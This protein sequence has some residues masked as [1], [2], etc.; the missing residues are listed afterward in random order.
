MYNN[1]VK[2]GKHELRKPEMRASSMPFCP[3]QYIF[4]WIDYFNEE[5]EWNYLGDFYCNIGTSVHESIQKWGPIANPGYF[6]GNWKCKRCK[7]T[8]R[9]KVGPQVCPTCGKFMYYDELLVNFVDAPVGG[10]CDGL[11]LDEKVINNLTKEKFKTVNVENINKLISINADLK[12]PAYVLELKTT[13]MWAIRNLSEPYTSHK[14]QAEIYASSLKR[15]IPV[16]YGNNNIN[17]KG[18][19]I[20]YISRDNP[21]I[22][23]T[24]FKK[25]IVNDILYKNTYKM[26]NKTIEAIKTGKVK[27]IFNLYPCKKWPSLYEGCDYDELCE[28]ISL[29]AFK[30]I[31]K[32]IK[33]SV[34]AKLYWKET[35][36]F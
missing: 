13:G 7:K 23:S 3:R 1:V 24:D 18:Y 30:A 22:V 9:F 36:I 19:L 10:H 8:E 16:R 12:I 31:V 35:N 25:D 26:V 14:C 21:R 28:N 4:K 20:K 29:K 32:K 17:V 15:V 34:G 33:G 6:L 11:L 27:K 2:Q 5:G